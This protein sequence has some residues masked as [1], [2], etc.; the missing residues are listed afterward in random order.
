[1]D[2]SLKLANPTQALSG[3]D[4]KY[5]NVNSSRFGWVISSMSAKMQMSL[6]A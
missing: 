2:L 5:R 4:C 3:F 1:M 6:L